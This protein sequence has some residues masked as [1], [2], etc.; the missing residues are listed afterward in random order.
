MQSNIPRH[1]LIPLHIPN[2]THGFS[3]SVLV[4]KMQTFRA[5]PFLPIKRCKRLQ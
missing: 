4:C 3:D 2:T 1:V 5:F